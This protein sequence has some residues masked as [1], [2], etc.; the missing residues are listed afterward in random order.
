MTRAALDQ[1]L[2]FQRKSFIPLGRILRDEA[3]LSV[4]ALAAALK[5]QTHVPRVYLRFFPVEREVVSLLDID[6]CRQ[7][8][9]IAFEKLGKLLCVAL[10]NPAQRN[11]IRYIE[12]QTSLEAK[13]FQAPWEDIQKKLEK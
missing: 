10:A 12:T 9:V 3:G 8:E 2:A 11:I 6:L 7:H 4:D 1:A 5:K 13:V